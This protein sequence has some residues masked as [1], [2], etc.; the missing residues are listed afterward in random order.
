VK[1][2]KAAKSKASAV[3]GSSIS[4]AESASARLTIPTMFGMFNKGKRS[5]PVSAK[6]SQPK[7]GM[8]FDETEFFG[9]EQL[10][11][12]ACPQSQARRGCEGR[13]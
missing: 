1:Q 13:I 2:S 6:G 4:S 5:K 8:A 9:S 11:E 7:I 12:S 10:A 3:Q